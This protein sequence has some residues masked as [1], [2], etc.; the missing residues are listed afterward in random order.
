MSINI[1]EYVETYFNCVKTK[2][3]QYKFYDLLQFLSVLK[4]LKQKRI[5][6][7]ITNLF[8]SIRRKTNY[9]NIFIVINH[10]FKLTGYIIAKKIETRKIYDVFYVLL[11]ELYINEFETNWKSFVI[12]IK[13]KKQ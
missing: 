6:N 11:F 2:T 10:F 9:D 5:V 13:E 3:F 1:N 7:F 4:K 12:E 8:S